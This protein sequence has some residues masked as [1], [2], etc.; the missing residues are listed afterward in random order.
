MLPER[1]TPTGTVE[2]RIYISE[3]TKP[4]NQ[5]GQYKYPIKIVTPR[6]D[7]PDAFYGYEPETMV[8]K[9]GY[10]IKQSKNKVANGS[11][12]HDCHTIYVVVY[13]NNDVNTHIIQ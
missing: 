13:P 10:T 1:K 7:K 11:Y 3:D 2:R 8:T 6:P 12:L 5:S 9:A 4:N